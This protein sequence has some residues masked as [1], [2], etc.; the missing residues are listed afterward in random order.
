M[1]FRRVWVRDAPTSTTRCAGWLAAPYKRRPGKIVGRSG[2]KYVYFCVSLS[3]IYLKAM[4]KLKNIL[5]R[6][7]VWGFF[8][9]VAVMAL[10]SLAFFYPDNFEGN[11]LRQPDM[12]Q[13]AANGHEGQ[14][15]EEAT[16]EKALWTNSLFGGMPTFQ[17]SPSYPSNSL[18]G[19]INTAYGLGL[20]APSNLLFMMMM[21]FLLL[22]YALGKRWYYALIGAVAWGLSSYFI[23][24]I[25]AGHIWKFLALTY[26]PPTIGGLLLVYRRHYL[27]GTAMVGLFAMLQLSA[28]HPQMSYYFGLLM[29]II[30]IC[31]L[32]DAIRRRTVRNWLV[33]TGLVVGAGV[34][35][36]GANAPSL[37][38]TYEYSK[39]TKRATSELAAADAASASAESAA[40][41][42]RPTGGMPKEQIVGWSYGPSEMFTLLVPDIKGGASARPRNGTM[43]SASLAD[44]DGA[45]GVD[46]SS[47]SFYVLS[48]LTQY[49]NDSEGTNGPVYVG[50]IMVALFILGIFIVRGPLKWA[51]VAGTAMALLLSLGYNAMWLTDWMIYHFPLYNKFRAVESILVVAEFCIPL[52]GVLALAQFIEAGTDSWSKYRKPLLVSFGLPGAVALLALVAPSAFGEL[53]NAADYS[54]LQDLHSQLAQMYAGNPDVSQAELQ[55]AIYDMSLANPENYRLVE[56]LRAGMVRSDALRSLLFLALALGVM[57]F[58]SLRRIRKPVAVGAVGVL[59]LVDLYGVDKRYVSHASFGAPAGVSQGIVPDA[60]DQA[61]LADT[62][63]HYRVLDIPGFSDARRSYFH[64]M[65]GGY[66]AAKLNRYEDLLQEKILPILPYAYRPEYQNYQEV[67]DLQEI[68]S[69]LNARYIITGD[70]ERPL[71]VNPEAMGNAWLVDS[72]IWVDGARQEMDALRFDSDLRHNAIAD[73][74]FAEALPE[75][76]SAAPGDTIYMTCYSPNTVRYHASTAAGGT[77]VFSEVYF[78]WGWKATIDDQ[79]API[80][81][82]NY[83]LRALSIPA[84]SHD[85]QMTFDP[86]SLHTTGAMAYA[87]VS[88]IYLLLLGGIFVE[89]HRWRLF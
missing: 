42:E 50:A 27:A 20:P 39:Y 74:S 89:A 22:M 25:G 10:I 64:S 51:M 54:R 46:P 16:G 66:H 72:V 4:N 28:N 61:I 32:I 79:P 26:V 44:L 9:S 85:I 23:I 71:L 8:V 45:R 47:G 12:I 70:R 40:P 87:C 52:L 38:N 29:G 86:D 30:V 18:F 77:G 43:V 31:C 62:T 57:T 65:L 56:G 21:G 41:A 5:S 73:R 48:Y 55:G 83:V 7:Q 33:G 76:P 14:L 35:A 58:Y 75:M 82:V 68:A 36:L 80:A 59:V 49:F 53:V 63:G 67:A 15:W 2:Y 11:S 6:P 3:V 78:P 88:L 24:I 1:L 84:G 13:G 34:L 19:W 60:L 81:R 69:M 37:Y 17:I